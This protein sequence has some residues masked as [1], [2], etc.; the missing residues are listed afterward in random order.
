ML[1]MPLT[2]SHLGQPPNAIKRAKG[3]CIY[4]SMRSGIAP[5]GGAGGA[6]V[7]LARLSDGSWSAPSAVSPN[8]LSAGLLL[9]IDFFDVVLLIVSR[10]NSPCYRAAP[11]S[12][13]YCSS[14][15]TDKAMDSF[16][17]HKFTVGAE[18]AIAAGPVGAGTS[19]EGGMERAPIY[20]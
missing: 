14:Q 15:N 19:L 12:L 10:C 18:T 1:P 4:S 9:G 11:L 7:V 13:N 3:I 6:G 5:F 2:R 8:N 17:T 16:R 20:S